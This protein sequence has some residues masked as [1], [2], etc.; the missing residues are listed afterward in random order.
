MRLSIVVPA[1]NEEAYLPDCLA[2]ILKETQSLTEPVEIIV[3]NNASTDRTREVALGFPGVRVVDE[4]RKGLTFARQA[5]LAAASGEF[6]ANIDADTRL[7]PGWIAKAE[8]MFAADPGMVCL[9]GPFRYYDISGPTKWIAELFWWISA[10]LTYRITGFMVL[11]ANFIAKRAAL[12]EIGGFDTNLAFY[13]EDTNL[14]LRL[15]KVGK[16]KFAMSFYILGSARRLLKE[17]LFKTFWVY[18]VNYCM[19]ALRIGPRTQAYN[20]I[21]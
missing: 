5:G 14:A 4:Q 7:P 1:Y 11:G 18:A 6:L 9:S 21:R 12:E 20:D 15:S 8:H 3:I 2:S 10:P 17:G 19:V 16:A 13:G